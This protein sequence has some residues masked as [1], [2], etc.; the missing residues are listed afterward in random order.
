VAAHV[1]SAAAREGG[2]FANVVQKDGELHQR[3]P[4]ESIGY[5]H[6]RHGVDIHVSLRVIRLRLRDPSERGDLRQKRLQEAK[7]LEEAD[8]SRGIVRP[9]RT[10]Q[11]LANPFA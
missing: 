9:Q 3:I 4:H 6:G 7:L 5:S 8:P 1:L 11:L 2:G 10:Q